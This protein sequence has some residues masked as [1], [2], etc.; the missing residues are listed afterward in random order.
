MLIIAFSPFDALFRIFIIHLYSHFL[1][2]QLL[3]L[4]CLTLVM[5]TF[6]LILPFKKVS[7]Q[8]KHS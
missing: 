7:S 3:L 8:R 4:P 6:M 5:C 1:Q 2:K